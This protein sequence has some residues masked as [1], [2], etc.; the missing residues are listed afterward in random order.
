MLNGKATTVL[1]TVASIKKANG[2]IF[3]IS[4]IRLVQVRFDLVWVT[5]HT[6]VF[7]FTM[8]TIK[9]SKFVKINSVNPLYLIFGSIFY[10][11]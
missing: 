11:K 6:K 7:L 1:L 9:D 3:S 10:L 4:E 5:S 2:W 8:M